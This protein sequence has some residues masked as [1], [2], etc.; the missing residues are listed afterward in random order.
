VY[1]TSGLSRVL[2]ETSQIMQVKMPLR[3]MVYPPHRRALWQESSFELRQKD[4]TLQD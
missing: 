4:S 1:L 3:A 2:T